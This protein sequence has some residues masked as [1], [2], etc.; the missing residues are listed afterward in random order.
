MRS[1]NILN[2]KHVEGNLDEVRNFVLFEGKSCENLC[3]LFG[4]KNIVDRFF[5]CT[6]CYILL[7]CLSHQQEA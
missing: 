4:K 1:M 6:R 2:Y 5:V 3:A 7:I